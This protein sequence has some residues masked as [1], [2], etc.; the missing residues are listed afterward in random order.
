[1]LDPVRREIVRAIDVSES[2]PLRDHEVLVLQRPAGDEHDDAEHIRRE[3]LRFHPDADPV[4]L[5]WLDRDSLKHPAH[6]V[7]V[8]DARIFETE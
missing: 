3:A 6:A 8:H 5:P 1:L 4:L 7:L 2:L